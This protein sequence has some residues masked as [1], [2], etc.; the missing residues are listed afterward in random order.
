MTND[1]I[2]GIFIVFGI[3]MVYVC[4]IMVKKLMKEDDDETE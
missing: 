3:A 1:I 2:L 4:M